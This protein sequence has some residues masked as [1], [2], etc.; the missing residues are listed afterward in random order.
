[1]SHLFAPSAP[2]VGEAMPPFKLF[3]SLRGRVSRSTFWIFGVLGLAGLGIVLGALLNIAGWQGE[4][5]E[6]FVNLLLLWPF[7]AVSAKR[8]HDRGH[9]AW[10]V[11]INLV[12]VLGMLWMLYENGLRAGDPAPNQY[13]PPPA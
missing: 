7:V 4:R 10:W 2:P 9:S 11:L 12:P 3:F 6:S 8:W 5:V 13:G 1:M